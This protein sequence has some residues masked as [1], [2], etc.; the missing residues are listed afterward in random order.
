MKITK[1]IQNIDCSECF[2]VMRKISRSLKD[3]EIFHEESENRRCRAVRYCEVSDSYEFVTIIGRYV[4]PSNDN[5]IRNFALYFRK[6]RK[7][8]KD[9]ETS[10]KYWRRTLGEG[11]NPEN[12]LE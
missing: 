2:Q 3:W 1:N 8:L 12:I 5:R 7:L 10:Q 9:R 6:K 11:V 4:F